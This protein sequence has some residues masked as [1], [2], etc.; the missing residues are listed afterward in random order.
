VN[1]LRPK[2]VVDAPDR[3]SWESTPPSDTF[4]SRRKKAARAAASERNR[5]RSE[6]DIARGYAINVKQVILAFAVEFWIM[7]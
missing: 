3:T 6:R 1:I 2:T 5:T 4:L 7:G